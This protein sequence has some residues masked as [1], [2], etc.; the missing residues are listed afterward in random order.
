MVGTLKQLARAALKKPL[1][2]LLQTPKPATGLFENRPSAAEM[3]PQ[4]RNRSGDGFG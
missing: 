2:I 1:A 4:S 3:T